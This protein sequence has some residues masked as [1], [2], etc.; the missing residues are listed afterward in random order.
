M[1]GGPEPPPAAGALVRDKRA[2][3]KIRRES[4]RAKRVLSS[5][6]QVWHPL[7]PS[8]LTLTLN[9]GVDRDRG[10]LQWHRLL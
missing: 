9:G 3:Q 4:E 6:M 1:S 2:L 10:A 5:A 7:T 8:T